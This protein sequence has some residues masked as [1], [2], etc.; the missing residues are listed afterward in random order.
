MV[1]LEHAAWQ[2]G[3]GIIPP[4]PREYRASE[5]RSVTLPLTIWRLVL[6]Q[7]ADDRTRLMAGSH[8]AHAATRIRLG[9][10]TMSEAGTSS[11]RID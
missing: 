7:L 8:A 4:P 5:V 2:V 6:K 10:E 1:D 9:D 11:G 3:K